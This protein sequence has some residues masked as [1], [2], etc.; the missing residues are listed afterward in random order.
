VPQLRASD[1]QKLLGVMKNPMGNQQD[2]I[3][4]LKQKS[5]NMAR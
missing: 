4:R 5:D 1:S 3:K 2:E